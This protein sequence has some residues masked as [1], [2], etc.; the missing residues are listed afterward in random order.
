MLIK[1]LQFTFDGRGSMERNEMAFQKDNK[2]QQSSMDVFRKEEGRIV[3]PT[4]VRLIR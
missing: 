4:G 1:V 2:C 3:T